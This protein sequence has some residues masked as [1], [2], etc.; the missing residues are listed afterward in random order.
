MTIEAEEI[1]SACDAIVGYTVYIDLVKK[2]F[3]DKELV[4]TPMKTEVDRVAAAIDRA[5]SGSRVALICSGDSG[6]YGM[7]GLAITMAS[8][9][10]VEVEVVPGLSALSSGAA[11][12]G[13]PLMSDFAVISLSD[14]LTPREKIER[15]I[16]AASAADLSICL[17]N[18]ASRGRPD[19]LAWACGLMLAHKDTSTIC[20]I[21]RNIGR[22]GE[23]AKI[24][25]L[26]EL[27]DAEADMFCT[28]FVGNS[29]T[30]VIDGRM[31][32]PRG[33]QPDRASGGR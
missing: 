23:S 26:A 21:A 13:A 12:L 17:Y 22:D 33:Y 29:E 30:K 16:V 32:T 11:L 7:A 10:D 3:P 27:K 1:L 8:G 9:R 24:M 18:P 28:V 31:V 14:L 20:G 6:V 25:T 5:A 4:A 15:R 2:I 19:M